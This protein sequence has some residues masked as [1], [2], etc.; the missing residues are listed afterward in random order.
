MRFER[1]RDEVERAERRVE[2]R[3]LRVRTN[4]RVMATT[5][6]EAWTPGR[7]LVLGLA[8]GA[9][10]AFARP[11]GRLGKVG[12]AGG[13]IPLARWIQLATSISGLVTALRARH[14]AESA[15]DAADD[16]GQVAEDAAETVDVATGAAPAAAAA[17]AQRAGP[18]TE[19]VVVGSVSDARRRPEPPWTGEP[20]AA[21]AAT[22]VSER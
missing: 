9:L 22:E 12:R 20:R 13:G 8:G 21:E 1:L 18:A 3:L 17:S 16:A 4:W 2:T 5:W 11:L 10:I 14:A 7:L 6:R 15:Q 19:P